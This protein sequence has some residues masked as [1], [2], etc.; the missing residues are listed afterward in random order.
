MFLDRLLR[1]AGSFGN[2]TVVGPGWLHGCRGEEEVLEN[3]TI[4]GMV[5]RHVDVSERALLKPFHVVTCPSRAMSSKRGWMKC[6]PTVE[7]VKPLM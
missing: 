6:R 5:S 4:Y 1:R 7:L 3:V 2:G